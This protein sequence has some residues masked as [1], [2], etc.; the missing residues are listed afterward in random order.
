MFRRDTSHRVQPVTRVLMFKPVKRE[1][2]TVQTEYPVGRS[3][4][5]RLGA[6]RGSHH[7]LSLARS[8]SSSPTPRFKPA[9]LSDQL[10]RSWRQNPRSAN[11]KQ[12]G[13]IPA[14]A[15]RACTMTTADFSQ[16]QYR[17]RRALEIITNESA[18]ATRKA[19]SQ[20]PMTY[21]ERCIVWRENFFYSKIL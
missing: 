21:V 13:K 12:T 9:S 17:L 20:W 10:A 1:R 18:F 5:V 16:W 4:P 6:A 3:H 8:L 11:H 2:K 15:H 7:G 19:F 14:D